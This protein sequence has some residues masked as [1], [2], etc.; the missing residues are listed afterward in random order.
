ME[1]LEEKVDAMY[2]NDNVTTK[3]L[4]AAVEELS[5]ALKKEEFVTSRFVICEKRLRELIWPPMS[6]SL[7][8]LF[9][10]TS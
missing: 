1:E 3:E 7:T 6:L 4:S 2:A 10:S 5:D 9:R 8:Y